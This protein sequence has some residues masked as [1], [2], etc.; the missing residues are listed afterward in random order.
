LSF[1]AEREL[2]PGASSLSQHLHAAHL[3][4][5]KVAK[6]SNCYRVHDAD[7]DALRGVT[8]ERYA[9]FALLHSYGAAAY[10]RR[11][12]LA[13]ALL[14]LGARGVYL[15]VRERGDLRQMDAAAVAPKE[16]LLGEAAAPELVVQEYNLKF[17]VRLADG[18]A[19]GLFIDQRENRALLQRECAGARVLNLFCYTGSFTVAA[20]AGAAEHVVSLDSSGAALARLN[21][22]LRLNDLAAERH[23]ILKDDAVK[24]LA[25]AAR[26][27]ARFD[28]IVLDPPS[29]ST[30]GN[31]S[32]S[33]ERQYGE[34]ARNS[35]QLLAPGGRLLAVTNHKKTSRKQFAELLSA[36]AVA[37][38]RQVLELTWPAA[39]EDCPL[40]TMPD[41]ATKSVIVRLS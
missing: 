6:V 36:A 25:R 14:E 17:W 38:R 9:D 4:R 2:A 13:Q 27:S 12:E 31:K 3:R 22:N 16:P 33:V 34:L 19:S 40:G 24:W 1:E 21:S 11:V 28:W 35:L 20:A 23:R 10:Q 7:A 15:K 30:R 18:I 26:Q 39:A 29:F 32:F 37:A 41:L 5:A 8:V